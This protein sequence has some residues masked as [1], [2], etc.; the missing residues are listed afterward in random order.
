[1]NGVEFRYLSLGARTSRE[2]IL[3][4]GMRLLDDHPDAW[5]N[6]V[7]LCRKRRDAD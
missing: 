6:H 2:L 5:D 7:Y 1:M 4:V 3:R